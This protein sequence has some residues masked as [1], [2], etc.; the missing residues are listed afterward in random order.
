MCCD[1]TGDEMDTQSFVANIPSHRVG[2]AAE[3]KAMSRK[4]AC[5][6]G[7]LTSRHGHRCNCAP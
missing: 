3:N 5:S 4:S 2:K 6:T 7:T 1:L